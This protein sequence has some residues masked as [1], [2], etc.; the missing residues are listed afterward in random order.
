MTFELLQSQ[1]VRSVLEVEG[2]NLPINCEDQGSASSFC[3]G[4]CP[5]NNKGKTCIED[6]EDVFESERKPLLAK[7]S[8]CE[9]KS[10]YIC[11]IPFQEDFRQYEACTDYDQGV[12]Q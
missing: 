12:G 1:F 8:V 5:L 10:G 9:T 6:R 7:N 4:S 2:A 11:Q 3:T